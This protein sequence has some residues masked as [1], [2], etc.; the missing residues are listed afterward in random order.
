[1]G[2]DLNRGD[3]SKTPEARA[4][5]EER[6]AK[7]RLFGCVSDKFSDYNKWW[8]VIEWNVIRDAALVLRMFDFGTSNDAEVNAVLDNNAS[9]LESLVKLWKCADIHALE[10]LL[11]IS[12][13]ADSTACARV[14]IRVCI[15]CS[16]D[17]SEKVL[18]FCLQFSAGNGRL[19][20]LEAMASSEDQKMNRLFFFGTTA[21]PAPRDASPHCAFFWPKE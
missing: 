1:M 8:S 14:C 11:M 6:D 15:N 13:M 10:S 17:M 2:N 20:Y 21:T 16:V 18:P 9:E 12:C 19:E 4:A 7:G 3:Y 5:R